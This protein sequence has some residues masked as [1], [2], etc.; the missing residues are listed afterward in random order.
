MYLRGQAVLTYCQLA[1]LWEEGHDAS[2][3]YTSIEAFL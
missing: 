2:S 3:T 1:G